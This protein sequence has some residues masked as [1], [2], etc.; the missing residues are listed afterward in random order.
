[1]LAKDKRSS[2]IPMAAKH[3]NNIFMTLSPQGKKFKF[4]I[5]FSLAREKEQ[6]YE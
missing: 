4:K 5:E 3:Y 6:H 1:M 2:L